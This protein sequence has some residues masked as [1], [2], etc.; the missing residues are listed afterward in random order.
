MGY[1]TT[2]CY[3]SIPSSYYDDIKELSVKK[4]PDISRMIDIF[5]LAVRHNCTNMS[6]CD[7]MMKTIA[8]HDKYKSYIR[9]A[10]KIL[11][12]ATERFPKAIDFL[13]GLHDKYILSI[14]YKRKSKYIDYTGISRSQRRH[15]SLHFDIS[16]HDG[17]LHFK[18][19]SFPKMLKKPHEEAD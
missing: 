2:G 16:A 13:H 11:E 5:R 1:D 15:C 19:I 4:P 3:Y 10:Q 18:K 7:V 8:Y 17:P 6:M 14:I 9:D 12:H